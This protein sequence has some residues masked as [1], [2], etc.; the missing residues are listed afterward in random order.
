MT[1]QH[2]NIIGPNLPDQSKG[3]FH[4]HA[5]GCRDGKRLEAL[6]GPYAGW[7]AECVD[8]SQVVVNVYADIIDENIDEGVYADTEDAV[9]DYM[10]EF[11]FAPCVEIS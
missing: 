10:H 6:A 9:R 11:H 7:V 5:A 1:T 4:V 8:R 3:Q 2:V